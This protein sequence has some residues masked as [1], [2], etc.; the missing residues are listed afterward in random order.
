MSNNTA[1]PVLSV[2]ER[3]RRWTRTREF[4][5]KQGFECLVLAG[6]TSREQY[7]AYLTND[8]AEGIVVLPAEGLPTYIT[9]MEGRVMR[10]KE[11]AERGLTPWVEDMRAG[12]DGPT[13]AAVMR[14]KGFEKARVGVVGLQ[15]RG[16]A[17]MNGYIP[18]ALWSNI[19]TELPHVEFVDCSEG[20]AAMMLV[21][22][23]EELVLMRRSAAI[24]EEA[25]R[26]ML[27][28][29]RPGVSEL[30]LTAEIMYTIFKAGAFSPPPFLVLHSGPETVSWGPPIWRYQ[31][32]VTR[33]LQ[34]GDMVMA[35][36]FPRYGGFESQQ[37]M[38]IALQPLDEV[39]RECAAL[40][41]RSY[42]K[43]LKVLRPG[44]SFQK[45]ADQ[46]EAVVMLVEIP[47]LL[48]GGVE[49]RLVIGRLGLRILNFAL[50]LWGCFQRLR[51][52]DRAG[53]VTV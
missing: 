43:G 49:G 33:T 31:G 19:L 45:V 3:D 5:K 14:E 52:L 20:F 6:L 7:D 12:V 50:K 27:E 22:S 37:Q 24:G 32:G 41:R 26:V 8:Y 30:E 1:F 15:S 10:Q 21:K 2:K 11:A 42:E 16:P 25:C 38:A 4:M 23:E 35:E 46:M 48:R 47:A 18:Y 39:H 29:A 36:I 44:V 34:K 40:A 53:L 17:E 13:L 9:W 51:Y 28:K